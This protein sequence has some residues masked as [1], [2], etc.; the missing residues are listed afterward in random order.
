ED[1]FDSDDQFV[2]T[3]MRKFGERQAWQLDAE[4]RRDSTRSEVEELGG[5]VAAT[6]VERRSLRPTWTRVFNEKNSLLVGGNWSDAEYDSARFSDYEQYGFDATW[7]RQLGERLSLQT[8]VYNS[9]FQSDASTESRGTES[10]TIGLR[11]T[12]VREFNEQLSGSLS[13]GARRVETPFLAPPSFFCLLFGIGC[14]VPVVLESSGFTT[15]AGL[16]Y[17]GETW[18][19][20]LSVSRSLNPD[21]LSGQL[22]ESDRISAKYSRQLRPSVFFDFAVEFYSDQSLESFSEFDR[23]RYFLTPAIR[24]QFAERWSYTTTVRHRMRET[25]RNA[26]Y[27]EGEATAI[28]FKVRYSHPR[29]RW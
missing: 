18:N 13:L 21:A 26:R 25:F 16:G 2:D 20:S 24:W 11:L 12:L 29:A 4:L 19:G 14:P 15:E 8:G 28:F 10:D 3:Q 6:R 27:S 22:L 1:Q 5:I 23:D 9:R 7:V 17:Q